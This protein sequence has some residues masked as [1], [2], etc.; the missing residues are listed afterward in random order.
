MTILGRRGPPKLRSVLSSR[1]CLSWKQNGI[2][3]RRSMDV[4]EM[5]MQPN[6]RNTNIWPAIS[7]QR[8]RISS[9]ELRCWNSRWRCRSRGLWRGQAC[10]IRVVAAAQ[11]APPNP[12][13]RILGQIWG[14]APVP[15]SVLVHSGAGAVPVKSGEDALF[16][17]E[18]KG[19]CWSTD[20]QP[21]CHEDNFERAWSV[22]SDHF[23]NK[24]LLVRSYLT[25]FTSLPKMKPESVSDFR[26]I[27]HG[28]VATVGALEGIGRPVTDGSDLFVHLIVEL[29]DTKTHKE[30]ERSLGRSA[31]PPSFSELRDFLE[32]TLL[33]QEVLRVS[34]D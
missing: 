4:C 34:K 7:S 24:R 1:P 2:D 16:E 10:E 5:N 11:G 31:V 18:R 30:W 27:F 19:Q 6:S 20:L 26:R 9:S 3:L 13:A 12:A 21:T 14:L 17:N 22:L 32:E 29:L 15:G 28:A 8:Q 25:A 23:E 33:T